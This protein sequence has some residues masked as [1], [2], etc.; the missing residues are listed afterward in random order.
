MNARHRGS[1]AH[2]DVHVAVV[3]SSL[4]AWLGS[5]VVATTPA[6][7]RELVD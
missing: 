6:G 2:A 1:Y 7:F 4:G 3:L 5:R